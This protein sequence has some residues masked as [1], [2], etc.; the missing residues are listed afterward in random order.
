MTDSFL[1]NDTVSVLLLFNEILEHGFDAQNFIISLGNHFRDLLV[2]K[3]PKTIDLLD[4]GEGIRLRYMEQSAKCDP[5]FLLQAIDICTQCDIHV[6][7]FPQSQVTGRVELLK[8]AGLTAE[9]KR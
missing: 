9:K 4:V 2:C 8:L 1:E 3:D 7:N 5:A 6:P